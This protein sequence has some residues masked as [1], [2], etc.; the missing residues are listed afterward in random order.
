MVQGKELFNW[1]RG[2]ILEH[3]KLPVSK[4]HDHL[5]E[6]YYVK[7]TREDNLAIENVKRFCGKESVTYIAHGN[8]RVDATF[9]YGTMVMFVD[10]VP[11]FLNG[12]PF[13]VLKYA[14]GSYSVKRMDCVDNTSDKTRH[15]KHEQLELLKLVDASNRPLTDYGSSATGSGTS[16]SAA[17]LE[18]EPFALGAFVKTKGLCKTRHGVIDSVYLYKASGSTGVYWYD[19]KPNNGGGEIQ[20]LQTI[21]HDHLELDTSH[22]R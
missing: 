8:L 14:A 19:F 13:K 16:V 11:K 20:S 10:E 22:V 12:K 6:S 2:T 9:R 7:F 3:P 21:S 15:V 1:M 4:S 5:R 18:V 17:K